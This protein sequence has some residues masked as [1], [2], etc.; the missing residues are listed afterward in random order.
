MSTELTRMRSEYRQAELNEAQA[1]NNPFVQFQHWLEQALAAGLPEPHAM[2]LSSVSAQGRPSSRTVLLRGF[3]QRGLIFYTNYTS[4]KGLEMAQ[5][6][7]VAVLF[8]WAELERQVR[9]EG[10]AEKI[11]DAESDA[12]FATRPRGSQIGAAVSPQ[13]QAIPDRQ[14]LDQLY[15]AHPAHNP[16][17]ALQRPAHWGGYLIRPNYF[18]FWQGRPSRLHDRL[19]Y[20]QTQTQAQWQRQRLAP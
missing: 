16:N 3:D 11:A 14:S 12:Y 1:D 15:A 19:A 13:S 17:Q 5:N 8:Y 2:I 20:T 7:D 18:E 9:I 4:R 10:R 6:P